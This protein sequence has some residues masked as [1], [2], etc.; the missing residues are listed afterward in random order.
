MWR[1]LNFNDRRLRPHGSQ[2]QMATDPHHLRRQMDT[3]RHHRLDNIKPT[4]LGQRPCPRSRRRRDSTQG[5]RDD[6]PTPDPNAWILD[7]V[8]R[9]S[10][11]IPA[12]SA[13]QCPLLP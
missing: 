5:R 12:I 11:R 13:G 7:P 8:R 1:T 4:T 10:I 3:L 6:S 2:L 9:P